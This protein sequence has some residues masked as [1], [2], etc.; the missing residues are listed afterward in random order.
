MT[1]RGSQ[2]LAW[3]HENRLA[4]VSGGVSE[5]YLYDTDGMRVK[6]T[7]DGVESY[8][9]FPH[10]EL[11]DGVVVK[12]YFFGG[13]RIAQRRDGV[14]TYL[15]GNHLGSTV[16]ETEVVSGTVVTDEKYFAYG[17]QRDTGP[18]NTENQY[19]DQKRDDTGLYYYGARYYDPA[20]GTF[21]SPDTIV[22]EPTNVFDYNRFMYVRGRPLNA[23]DPDGRRLYFAP[24]AGYSPDNG[25]Y[26]QQMLAI[27]AEAGIADPKVLEAHGNQHSDIFFTVGDNSRYAAGEEM[28]IAISAGRG[29]TSVK[30]EMS[31]DWRVSEAFNK[32]VSDL[33][34]NPLAEGEQLNL[35]GYS[36]GSVIVAQTALQLAKD[37]YTLDNLILVGT[38]ILSDSSLYQ[39]LEISSNIL[40][41]IRVDIPGDETTTI[42]E[43]P[44][45]KIAF[46]W[47][48]AN[49]GFAGHPHFSY[50]FN[51]N[52]EANTA[53]LAA[54]LVT[55][56]VR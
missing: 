18:V 45:D 2:T 34:L 40:N 53:E 21:V 15:H 24:G 32:I 47:N 39:E 22:P 5:D 50:S 37:G 13:M 3:D 49:Q 29:G 56:G 25:T 27:L 38:P 36:T 26:A 17:E 42:N 6:K 52:A 55:Q 19:T 16:L 31:L 9:P 28:W 23:T 44:I 4:S 30:V 46:M 8:Y 20:L 12:Y 33:R 10:Y 7:S 51:E 48:F 1:T 35:M 11:H 43:N 14:L 41:V 54:D